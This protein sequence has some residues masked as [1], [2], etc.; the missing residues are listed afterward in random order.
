MTGDRQ[1]RWVGP[2]DDPFRYQITADAFTAGI[3]GGQGIVYQ[4][5]TVD[6]DDVAV[7][8]M[9]NTPASARDEVAGRLAAV[10]DA[11]H[12][13]LGR[14][15]E[16]FLG[17][18]P[19]PHPETFERHDFETV[20]EVDDWVN[21]V[22][23]PDAVVDA[24]LVDRLR[25][26]S[27]L[28]A[29]VDHLHGLRSERAPHGVVHRDIKPSNVLVTGDGDAVL[30]DF[31]VARPAPAPTDDLSVGIGT[32]GWVAPEHHHDPAQPADPKAADR[33][34]V[35]AVA[36]AA[37][38]GER[39]PRDT[40][41]RALRQL[42]DGR[43]PRWCPQ[44]HRRRRPHRRSPALRP[45]RTTQ[46]PSPL[47]RAAAVVGHAPAHPVAVGVRRHVRRRH[48]RGHRV[49]RHPRLRQPDRRHHGCDRRSRGQP[50]HHRRRTG[51]RAHRQQ[52]RPVAATT[53]STPAAGTAS[54]S[55]W[56]RPAT[57]RTCATPNPPPPTS[58]T[59]S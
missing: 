6:G 51:R 33:W 38:T 1:I 42:T 56:L 29:A 45:A 18:A 11:E 53:P 44:R 59:P 36:Y 8:V 27:Q 3:V 9:T 55:P 17:A 46:R 43:P 48:H 31:G 21:G 23:L 22:R 25:W 49:P 15:R 41:P 2:A 5:R 12:P 19:D 24:A 35:G 28:A 57:G 58:A 26:I 47:G 32:L 40:H 52:R 14:Y 34:A 13:N 50:D 39:P 4:A 54:K 16:C 10:A 7:K 37:F 20:I 30:V